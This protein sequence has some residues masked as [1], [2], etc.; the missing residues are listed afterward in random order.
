MRRND[1]ERELKA[2]MEH[3]S[4]KVRKEP[5]NLLVFPAGENLA[6]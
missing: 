3:E 6:E 5:T 2:R 1:C 4:E